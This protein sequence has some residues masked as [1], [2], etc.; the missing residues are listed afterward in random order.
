LSLN[1]GGGS[2]V[3]GVDLSTGEIETEGNLDEDTFE[4]EGMFDD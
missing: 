3:N 2:K 4:Q 1:V